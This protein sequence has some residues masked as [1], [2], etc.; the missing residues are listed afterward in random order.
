VILAMFVYSIWDEICSTIS[1]KYKTVRVDEV[2]KESSGEKWISIKHDV[3]TNVAKALELAKI[4]YKYGI[5]ATYYVQAYLLEEN[6][7]ALKEI[8][9]LGHEV[10]YHY[11]VLDAN[12]GDYKTAEVDFTNMIKNF[13]RHGFK[14]NTVCPHGN[15]M[16][17]RDGWSSN[18]D[19][20]RNESI[21]KKFPDI[22]DIVVQLPKKLKNDYTYISDAGYGWK[23]IANVNNNDISNKGDIDLQNY[24]NLLKII[25][26]KDKVILSTHPH[27][28]EKNKLKFIFN[29]VFFKVVRFIAKKTS[30]ISILKKI[31]SKYYYLAKKV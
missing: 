29:V 22:L 23:E 10:T 15:P 18:K 14:I 7:D 25:S 19:F 28:W 20:F 31:M 16:M 5:Q 8:Q 17:L 6:L 21:Q 4:E 12:N 24:R 26:K 2:L 1:R 13:T 11:D 30:K 9:K 27:R 3:E